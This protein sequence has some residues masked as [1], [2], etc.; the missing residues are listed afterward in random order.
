M[1]TARSPRRLSLNDDGTTKLSGPRSV[2]LTNDGTLVVSDSLAH[3][4]RSGA[5]GLTGVGDVSI[6]TTPD[7]P[8]G[9]S[10]TED[11]IAPPSAPVAGRRVNAEPVQGA[12]RVRL[13]SGGRW[14]SLR[15]AGSIPVGAVVDTRR[16]AV[17]VETIP[18]ATGDPQTATLSGGS[19]RIRQRATTAAVTE[20]RLAARGSCAP[21]ARPNRSSQLGATASAARKRR[22]PRLRAKLWAK[23]NGRFRTR[24][25]NAAAT[26]RGTRWL[27]EDTCAGTRV[28]VERGAVEV[29]PAAG[30]RGVVVSAGEQVLVRRGA[31]RV[32]RR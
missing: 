24:G 6:A 32:T 10:K 20:F 25:R 15:E 1:R 8:P 11:A 21:A 2:A 31:K 23:G 27:T 3:R 13:S 28:R 4:V 12:V 7:P 5:S 17:K 14:L 29:R 19:F 9:Y 22:S 30:G 18:G 16:G 26:V